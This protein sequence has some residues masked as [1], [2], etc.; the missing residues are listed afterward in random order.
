[1][2]VSKVGYSK[3]YPLS[4]SGAWEKI[5][6]E[7]DLNEGDDARQALYEC[8][9]QVESFH[10]ES[11]K[12]AEKKIEKSKDT[13]GSIIDQINSCTEVKVLESYKIIAKSKV[14]IQEAYDN[15]LKQLQNGSN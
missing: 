4:I 8:K 9:R 11:N 12:A 7:A 3:T 14:E 10:F 15:K 1:M 13:G 5:F 2:Q 6:V